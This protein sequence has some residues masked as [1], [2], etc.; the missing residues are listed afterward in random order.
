MTYSSAGMFG[1][2]LNCNLKG[3]VQYVKI[4]SWNKIQFGITAVDLD[5]LS[6]TAEMP[7]VLL[8]NPESLHKPCGKQVL[9]N[10]IL[11]NIINIISNKRRNKSV[12][13]PITGYLASCQFLATFWTSSNYGS[14]TFNINERDSNWYGVLTEPTLTLKSYGLQVTSRLQQDNRRTHLFVF[15]EVHTAYFWGMHSDRRT[16]TPFRETFADIKGFIRQ[17]SVCILIT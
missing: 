3:R 8:S 15:D 9:N 7:D 14:K 6:A 11:L 1:I 17:Y 5:E 2:L 16:G 12:T 10:S 4:N 13:A